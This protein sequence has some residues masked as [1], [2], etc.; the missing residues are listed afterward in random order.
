MITLTKWIDLKNCN[1]SKR[2]QILSFHELKMIEYLMQ[3]IEKVL[4]NKNERMNERM[5]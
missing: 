3:R 5:N 4:D 2:K 1:Y